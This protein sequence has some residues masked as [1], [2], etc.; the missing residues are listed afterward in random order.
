MKI[1]YFA[2]GAQDCPLILIYGN[3]PDAIK[4]LQ[5][6]LKP[7]VTGTVEQIAIHELPGF[8]SIGNCQL[9][10]KAQA[11]DSGVQQAQ[12]GLVF[13]CGLRRDVWQDVIDLL[14]PFALIEPGNHVRFQYL[15]Q[16]GK[17]SLLVSTS[18]S[19]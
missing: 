14:E 18:R 3:E 2:D 11:K 13:V 15:T 1:E 9:F 10:A 5:N 7:L 4:N 12:S 19:W 16:T 17:I 8:V 6:A